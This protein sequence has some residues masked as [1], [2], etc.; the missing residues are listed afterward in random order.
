MV[1]F[2]TEY[3]T[4]FQKCLTVLDRE[5]ID[6][7]AVGLRAVRELN[8][9]VFVLGNGG[10]AANASHFVNDLRKIC[11]I[12][13]YCPTDNVAEFS[14][15][16]N[17]EPHATVFKNWLLTS[18]LS[19]A[20]GIFVLSVNGGTPTISRNLNEAIYEAKIWGARVFGIVGA[21]GGMTAAH[22]DYCVLVPTVEDALITPFVES[23]QAVVWHCLV[24]HPEL[25]V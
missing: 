22:A 11:H 1:P 13:A 23:M 14:A 6:R 12:E 10:S 9:R 15:R 25:K 3:L 4:A 2:A 20:D 18:Q 5:A 17:D 24:N 7:T 19:A 21:P 16:M 8:G